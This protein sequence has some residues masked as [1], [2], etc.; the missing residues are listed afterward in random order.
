MIHLQIPTDTSVYSCINKIEIKS[1]KNLDIWVYKIEQNAATL[2]R[3][4]DIFRFPRNI[5][6]HNSIALL[7]FTDI[8]FIVSFHELLL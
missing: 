7:I 8:E 6:K 3:I 2:N 5:V 4:I 1:V